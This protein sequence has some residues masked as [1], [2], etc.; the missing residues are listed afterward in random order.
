MWGPGELDDAAAQA[1]DRAAELA[2]SGDTAGALGVLN[3]AHVDRTLADVLRGNGDDG[4]GLVGATP[5]GPARFR[6]PPGI[7]I[8]LVPMG[9]C[10]TD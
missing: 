7:E 1:R 6:A 8:G 3:A 10:G 5:V 9:E 2:D 4:D